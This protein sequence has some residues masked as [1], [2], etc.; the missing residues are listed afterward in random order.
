MDVGYN[1]NV[2]ST[3]HLCQDFERLDV[4]NSSKRIDARTIGLLE[5]S[6]E[7][8]RDVEMP[9][10]VRHLFGNVHCHILAFN[11]AWAGKQEKVAGSRRGEIFGNFLIIV[12][13][14]DLLRV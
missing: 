11:Y 12:H 4:T 1:R 7:Y 3:A 14:V 5:T 2:E 9:G 10:N 8:I 6:L 13:V